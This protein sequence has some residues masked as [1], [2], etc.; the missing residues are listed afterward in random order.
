[1]RWELC[2]IAIVDVTG[3]A[4]ASATNGEYCCTGKIL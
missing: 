3:A 1:M 2:T 4:T